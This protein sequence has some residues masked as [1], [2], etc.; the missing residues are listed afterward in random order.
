MDVFI[1]EP[2][3]ETLAADVVKQVK[4]SKAEEIDV[5]IMSL[6]GSMLAGNAIVDTLKNSPAK[7]TTNVIGVAASMG[8]VISQAGDE[9]YIAPDA[10]FNIHHGA[11][12]A[13]GGRGTKHDHQDAIETLEKMDGQMIKSFSKT[14]LSED[15][16]NVI[17]RSDKLF[18]AD[19]AITLG[20]FDGYAKSAQAVAE[21]NKQIKGMSK[22]SELMAAVDTAAIKMG[23]KSTDDDAKK[24][25]VAALEEELKEQVEEQ[26]MEVE[27]NPETGAD[28][29]TSEMVSREEFEMFKA[30]VLALI[31]PL[32]GA[33]EEL[34]TPE[35]TTETVEE[36]TTAKL[37]NLLQ[38]IKSKTTVPAAKQTFEQPE[39]VKEDWSEYEAKKKEIAEKNQR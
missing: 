25:L 29:L 5:H 17:M 30:E 20:F 7:V 26:V 23:I 8:A 12:G 22:L 24:K 38:A 28:I 11:M 39:E 34:P 15:D 33:V 1:L 4:G 6:G 35:Q 16:L 36:V 31:K 13:T 19:E 21:Y 9:R 18:T 27:A 32:L 14:G 37:D 2:I 10:S 3:T